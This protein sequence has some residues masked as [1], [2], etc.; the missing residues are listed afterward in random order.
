MSVFQQKREEF[1]V[2]EEVYVYRD[3]YLSKSVITGIK[4]YGF[5]KHYMITDLDL[6]KD[7]ELFHW[8][9]YAI[10][11]VDFLIH[12]IEYH[13]DLA[14]ANLKTLTLSQD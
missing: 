11:D 14:E 12:H 6:N 5:T 2:G 9:V 4:D 3:N 1:R 10:D 8:D 13:K 7:I